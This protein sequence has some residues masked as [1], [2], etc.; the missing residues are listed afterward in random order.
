MMGSLF[1]EADPWFSFLLNAGNAVDLLEGGNIF[2]ISSSVFFL[3]ADNEN[4]LELFMGMEWHW[5]G[6]KGI[7]LLI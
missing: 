1:G 4:L 6:G 7:Q 2:W 3:A 5:P